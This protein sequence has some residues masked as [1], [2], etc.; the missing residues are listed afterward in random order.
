MHHIIKIKV[1]LSVLHKVYIVMSTYHM[2]CLRWTH[3]HT[4]TK[5]T[6]RRT[7]ITGKRH[8]QLGLGAQG[9]LK[10]EIRSPAPT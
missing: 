5:I 7:Y 1:V 8:I 3:I 6:L 2:S 10:V 4:L 9:K